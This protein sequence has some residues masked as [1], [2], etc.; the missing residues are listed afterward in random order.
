MSGFK[1][2]EDKLVNVIRLSE[3]WL[4]YWQRGFWL[5]RIVKRVPLFLEWNK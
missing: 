5:A 3:T 4:G 1:T 2:S